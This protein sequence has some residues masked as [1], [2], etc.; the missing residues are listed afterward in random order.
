MDRNNS[1][2]IIENKIYE[3]RGVK[4][5]FDFDLAEMYGMETKVLKQAVRR[6]IK[7]FEGD[8]F[9]FEVSL[10]ELSRSQIVTLNKGRGQNVKYKPFA[11]TELGVAMLSSV[12]N[13][14]IAIEVNRNIMRT[15]TSIRNLILN[16]PKDE[17]SGLKQDIKVLQ[18]QIEDM[19]ADQNDI[20]EDTR[21]QLDLI[22]EAL[23]ELQTKSINN[24]R[25]EIGYIATLNRND[26]Q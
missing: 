23:A 2:L 21:I 9:M 12:L 5:M 14:E 18:E 8:D 26:K 17:L 16:S 22:N 3:L 10:E 20:N 15:F 6:N 13:S 24:K 4:V 19:F 25:N 11:F 1:L 7:R